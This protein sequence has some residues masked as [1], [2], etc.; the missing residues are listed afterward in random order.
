M[1]KYNLIVIGAGPGGYVAAVEAAKLGQ[2][3]AVIEKEKIGGTCLNVGCIPSKAYLKH[4]S[5]VEE[6]KEANRFGI[7]NELGDIDYTK[8][9]ERKNGVVSQLQQGIH[10]LFK[11][12]NIDYYEGEASIQSS[13]EIRVNNEL[14]ES[15]YLLLATGSHP[16]VPPINGIENSK[17]LTTD[18]FFDLKELPKE[19]VII[20]GGVIGV[21]LAFAMAP[22]GTKVTIIEV[23]P[24]ILMTEDLEATQII[25]NQLNKMKVQVI[26]GATIKDVEAKKVILA[27]QEISFDEL[28]VVTGRKG[29][30]DLA[31]N[32]NLEKSE[33]KKFIKTNRQYQTSV[34]NVYA[35]GDII[36]GYM[37]AHA[38]SKEGTKA[39]RHMF[40]EKE[41]P[42]KNEQ[43]P[44]CVYTHPEIASFGLSEV[45][46]KE[47]GFD[48]LVS[49]TPYSA[50]G[51]AIA[52]N[53]TTGF[54]K[55]IA[56]KKYHEILGAVIVGSNA[57]E[58]IHTILAVK[59][60][61][62]RLEEIEK[63]TFAHPTLSEMI[64]ELGSQMI[65]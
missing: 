11:Q 46:A 40:G 52:G 20:G 22:L 35:V 31:E 7:S 48:V 43:V 55:V 41:A 61:E 65:F 4:A 12:N 21:E 34:P 1:K 56:D 38:A 39:V 2:K 42:L 53:E 3:V 19:L 32:L 59:E 30:L 26:E 50:N 28:L 29:N 9:V 63:M 10:Y 15:D 37:L 57:T 8:L 23:A 49:K 5:W 36:D 33:N 18:T 25:K 64:G 51:R 62:G 27:D 14:L 45:E 44:R 60:S 13:H 17:Y 58:M 54:I 47:K 24:S 16:F 6:L